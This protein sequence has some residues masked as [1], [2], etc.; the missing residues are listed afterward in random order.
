[1]HSSHSPL[2]NSATMSHQITQLM[3]TDIL[4]LNLTS[5]YQYM[6]ENIG[7]LHDEFLR[8]DDEYKFAAIAGKTLKFASSSSNL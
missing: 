3:N 6:I 5:V 1:M 8:T 4:V 7:E 2:G